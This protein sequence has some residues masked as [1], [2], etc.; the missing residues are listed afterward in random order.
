MLEAFEN[1]RR[2]PGIRKSRRPW[3]REMLEPGLPGARTQGPG[4]DGSVGLGE[5]GRR[6]WGNP[7]PV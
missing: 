1:R 5:V 4:L 6:C 3:R 7:Q 2:K